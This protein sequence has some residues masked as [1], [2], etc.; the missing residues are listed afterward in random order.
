MQTVTVNQTT[1]NDCSKAFDELEKQDELVISQ[2]AEIKLLNERLESEKEKK[3]IALELAESRRRE[4]QSEREAK[5]AKSDVIAAKDETIAA[6]DKQIEN[7]DKEI[8]ILK[9]RKISPIEK[10]KYIGLG[11]LI[12][13]IS[14]FFF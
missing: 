1:L 14:G 2:D 8:E 3:S 12:G 13:K 9:K 5:E 11:F 6:K 10:A 7:K 4:A